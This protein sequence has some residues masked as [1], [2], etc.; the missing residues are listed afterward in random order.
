MNTEQAFCGLK[1]EKM[2]ELQVLRHKILFIYYIHIHETTFHF[3]TIC[4]LFIFHFLII[5]E[6]LY[7]ES[8]DMEGLQIFDHGAILCLWEIHANFHIIA[9]HSKTRQ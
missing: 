9:V 6:S 7:T 3:V 8:S 1:G 2:D 5:L 4:I